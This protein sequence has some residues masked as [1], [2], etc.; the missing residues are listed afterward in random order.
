MIR[1]LSIGSVV[2][3][4]ISAII[5]LITGIG[6]LSCCVREHRAAESPYYRLKS[7]MA[8]V[9]PSIQEAHYPVV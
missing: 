3:L 6:G 9:Q 5:T 8:N 1:I 4:I 7:N 2:M